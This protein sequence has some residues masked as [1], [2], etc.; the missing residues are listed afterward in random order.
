MAFNLNRLKAE[1]VAR[2]YTQAQF[3]NKLH[4]SREAYA[5]RESGKV[6]ISVEE[7]ANILQ[8]LGYDTRNMSIFFCS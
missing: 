5:K 2:G 7:F 1:R 3:A 6:N 8:A 4:M